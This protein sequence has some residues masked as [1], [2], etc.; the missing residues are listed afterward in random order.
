MSE[1]L[2]IDLAVLVD[3]ISNIAGMMILF[4]CFALLAKVD[5]S[6]E[7]PTPVAKPINFPLA[8]LPIKKSSVTIVLKHGRLY[9]LPAD[10]LLQQVQQRAAKGEVVQ[11]L[12]LEQDGVLGRIELTQAALGFRFKYSMLP[13]G[14]VPLR[15]A[16]KVKEV[17]DELVA[18]Y[19]AERYFIMVHVWPDEFESF[20]N[21]REY[22]NEKQM[23]V[24]WHPRI[25]RSPNEIWDVTL[26]VGEYSE[27]FTSIKAQ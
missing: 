21:I 17:L 1:K 18:A 5:K 24:G 8:Y 26:A 15:S 23:E 16:L 6:N 11:H 27:G 7:P 20:R 25:T 4:A 9:R 13:A 22:L 3:I 19:P 10:A 14:G 2:R 12:E